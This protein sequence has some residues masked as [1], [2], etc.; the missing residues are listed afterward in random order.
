VNELTSDYKEKRCHNVKDY[1]VFMHYLMS[2]INFGH[3]QRPSV[4][5]NMKVREFVH[6]KRATD[7]RIVVLVSEHKTDASGPAQVALEEEHYQQ[8]QQYLRKYDKQ[9][10]EFSKLA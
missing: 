7:G 5:S 2:V 4:V 9:L 1:N 8:F 3:F 10:F 6:A